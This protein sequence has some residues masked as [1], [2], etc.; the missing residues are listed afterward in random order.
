MRFAVA[1]SAAEHIVDDLFSSAVRPF[2][3]QVQ[4]YE[5]LHASAVQTPEGVIAFCGFSGDGKTTIAYGLARKGH[6]LWADDA[7]VLASTEDGTSTVRF[8]HAV[9]LRS[10]A[11]EFFRLAGDEEVKLPGHD[12]R[13]DRLAALVVLGPTQ[14]GPTE[15]TSLPLGEA[16]AAVLP[17]AFCFFAEEGRAQKTVTAYL[18]VVSHIP[19][20]R[21]HVPRDLSRLGETLDL[22]DR[23]L[24]EA[25]VPG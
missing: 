19:V 12:D 11:R 14:A 18:D 21:L 9:N 7:V 13:V 1:P 2:F 20:Y 4:G 16:L 23:S 24:H 8:P 22:L 5:V 6:A 3:L 10:A 25:V 15:L 17:H